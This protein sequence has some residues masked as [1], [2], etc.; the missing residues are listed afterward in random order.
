M[1]RGRKAILALVG[2]V[3]ALVALGVVVRRRAGRAVA[4]P[5]VTETTAAIAST[6]PD[7]GP[8]QEE[9]AFV[10]VVV[11]ERAVDIVTRTEGLL[12]AVPVK[13][14]QR[15]ADNDIVARVDAPKLEH[16]FAIAKSAAREASVD[17]ARAKAELT[18]ATRRVAYASRLVAASVGSGEELERAQHEQKIATLH[19]EEANAK[20]AQQQSRMEELRGERDATTLRAPFAGIVAARYA[21]PGSVVQALS[22]VVRVVAEGKSLIRFAVPQREIDHAGVGTEV[23]ASCTESRGGVIRANVASVAPEVDTAANMLFVEATVAS[24]SG[25]VCGNGEVVHVVLAKPD[26]GR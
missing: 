17:L 10:G 7:A 16:D 18:E 4:P 12:A 21:E 9:A 5:R 6:T 2:V 8:V 11:S 14:G 22:R 26:A 19:I 23:V 20:L 25:P 1:T 3:M 15:I 24:A 13:V